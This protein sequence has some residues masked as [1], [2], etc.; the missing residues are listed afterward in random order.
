MKT[1]QTKLSILTR[2]VLGAFWLLAGASSHG[3]SAQDFPK[4]LKYEL[5]D[6]E[7]A[8]GDSIVIRELSG[9]S[10][11]V[12]PGGVYCVSGDYTLSSQAEADLSFFAT[13]TNRTP[14]AIDAEQTMHV[15][16][17]TGTFRLVKKMTEPGYLHLTF[18][19]QKASRGFGG[20]YFGQGE[21]VLHNKQFSYTN[22]ASSE[23]A[24]AREVPL[25]SGPNAVLIEY[26]G[27]PV[28]PPPGMDAAYSKEG[29]MKA[30]QTAAANARVQ[31]KRIDI[32]DSEFPFLVGAAFSKPGDKEKW[33]EQIGKLAGYVCSGGTSSDTCY[34]L[35]IVPYPA[36]PSDAGQRIYRRLMLREAV[37]LEKTSALRPAPGSTPK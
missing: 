24:T 12:Q 25:L 11:E 36:F 27:N 13:T 30:V 21:W 15:T 6:R 31:L 10:E 17:G 9:T 7:F 3:G 34:A 33:G 37:L 14:T 1:S 8:P 20:V 16:K 26:L 4:S 28:P 5:G 19:S 23:G 32:D 22:A 2:A 29:L 35:N 18:Y